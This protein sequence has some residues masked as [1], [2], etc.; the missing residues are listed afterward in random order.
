MDDNTVVMAS[1]NHYVWGVWLV[2]ASMRMNSMPEPVLILAENYSPPD[3]ECLEQFGGVK[4]IQRDESFRRNLTY[5]KPEAMLLADTDYITWV[6]C[7]ALF[8]GNCSE[9]LTPAPE[10]IHIRRRAY[11]E[12][13]IGF[14]KFY[15]PN[16]KRGPIP[17]KI[18]EVWRQDIGEN[19]QPAFDTCC[20]ACFLSLH[21]NY[22]FIL[23]KWRT[24]IEKVMPED[25]VGVVDKRSVAYFQTDESVLNSVLCF[26]KGAPAVVPEYKLDKDPKAFFIHFNY[27]PKPWRLWNDYTIKH[28]NRT[29]AVVEWALA[30]NYRMPGPVPFALKRRYR[31]FNHLVAPFTR[32]YYRGLKL[33]H[34]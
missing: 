32:S 8:Y 28:F 25:N 21:R 13:R 23:E 1:D 14:E 33:L 5:S 30:N 10:Y 2:I 17:A 7:D 29:V 24:Q 31:V 26:C 11:A 9:Y 12:N 22:R 16:E 15:A 34:R 6:D 4:I 20:S 3:L 27:Q 19:R 18:L